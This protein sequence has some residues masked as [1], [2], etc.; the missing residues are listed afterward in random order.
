MRPVLSNLSTGSAMPVLLVLR[1][2]QVALIV[3]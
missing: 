2:I 3:A 1:G